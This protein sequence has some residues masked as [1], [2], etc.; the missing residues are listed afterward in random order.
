MSNEFFLKIA[1]AEDADEIHSLMQ[2]VYDRMEDKSL[3]VC[4]DMEYVRS[5][6][7]EEG[8]TV[9]AQNTKGRIIGSFIFSYPGMGSGNLGKD[10]GLAAA[11][12]EKVVHVDSA[13]V[14][15]EC[16][17]NGLQLKMLRFAEELIDKDR[18]RYFMATVSPDNPASYRS[19]EKNGYKLMV[20]KEKYGGL[21]RRIYLKKV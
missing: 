8:F 13:V 18:Y 20:T 16:R 14:L 2:T 1:A 21:L 7:S 15:P 17:G 5:H 10:I 6:I 12:L 19:L 3:F 4:D 11:E 9:I